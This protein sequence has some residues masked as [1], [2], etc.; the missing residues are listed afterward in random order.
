MEMTDFPRLRLRQE[1]TL[2]SSLLGYNVSCKTS[3][4][5]SLTDLADSQL[6][7]H[8]SSLAVFTVRSPWYD[9]RALRF[10]K[11]NFSARDDIHVIARKQPPKYLYRPSVAYFYLIRINYVIL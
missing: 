10:F 5:I 7:A 8:S 1:E 2:Y 11:G 6:T 4:P 3:S 9:L